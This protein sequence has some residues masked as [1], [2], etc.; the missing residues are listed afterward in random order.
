MYAALMNIH[1]LVIADGGEGTKSA[2]QAAR[3]IVQTVPSAVDSHIDVLVAGD[4]D[5]RERYKEMMQMVSLGQQ[6]PMRMVVA[7][8]EMYRHTNIPEPYALLIEWMQKR[9]V[10]VGGCVGICN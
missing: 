1:T 4:G 8:D 6:I 9:C 3:N 7:D 10:D 5:M 2:I